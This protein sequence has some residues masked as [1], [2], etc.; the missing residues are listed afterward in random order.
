MSQIV[1]RAGRI[2]ELD[3]LRGMAI[4]LMITGH[5]ILVHPIDFTA[6]PWCHTL[7]V[8]I[9]SFHM[10]LFFLISGAV[11]YCADYR[12]YIRKRIDR[13]LVPLFFVGIIA[14]LFHSFG[15]DA[16]HKHMSFM[17]GVKGLLLFGN[18]YWFLYTLFIIC[19]VYP[20]I[21]KLCPN[22]Y[23]ELSIAA[24]IIII[25]CFVEF[26]ILFRLSALTYYLPYFIFGRA[27][28]GLMRI[29]VKVLGS[30]VV[31]IVCLAL[32]ALLWKLR[33]NIEVVNYVMAFAMIIPFF[34]LA[35]L[36]L[37]IEK[38]SAATGK[39]QRAINDFLRSASKYSLQ[40]YLFN[41]FILVAAR[42]LVVNIIHI[43]NPILV[44]PLIVFANFVVT[45]PLCEWLLSRLCWMGWLCGVRSFPLKKTDVN[46]E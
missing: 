41:G 9:Y 20:L 26:P 4:V 12:V 14:I 36:L 10:E 34:F 30:F 31:S 1:N 15:G 37:S 16:V 24:L 17:D 35:R 44:I 29:E 40:V 19:A 13:L 7:H 38:K 46:K 33:I 2:H 25:R 18:P 42:V 39:A 11:Y 22:I 8:W 27:L 43:T 32:Y 28:V 3:L 45:L 21:E 5:S 23:W 6:I